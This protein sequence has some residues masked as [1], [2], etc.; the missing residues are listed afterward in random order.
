VGLQ[1]GIP[2]RSA[3]TAIY[4]LLAGG[5]K[6]VYR[7]EQM[8]ICKLN[9]GRALDNME[10]SAYYPQMLANELGRSAALMYNFN[11]NIC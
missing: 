2:S 11:G 6:P 5:D 1:K 3:L 7:T 8:E 9:F 4:E 10:L